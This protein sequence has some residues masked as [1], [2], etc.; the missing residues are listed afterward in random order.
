MTDQPRRVTRE[1]H[2]DMARV[3]PDAEVAAALRSERVAGN[4]G[5]AVVALLA[6]ERDVGIAEPTKFAAPAV[7]VA[8]NSR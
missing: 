5:D 6:I 4:D 3:A 8:G 2:G 7:A 1:G